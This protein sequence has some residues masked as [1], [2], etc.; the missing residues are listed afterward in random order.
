MK[1][2]ILVPTYKI[3]FLRECIDSI[4]AQTY[5]DFE[6][7]IVNDASPYDIDSIVN[8]YHDNRIRYYK[9]EINYGAVNVVDNWNKCLSYAKGDYVI[10]MGDDDKLLPC[11]LEEYN[12]LIIQYPHLDIYHGWTEIIN[13][14]SEVTTL[15]E[16]RPIWESVYSMMW[17]RWKYRIQFIG[18]FLFKTSKLKEVG[19]FY[20]LPLAW[21]SDDVTSYIL[22]EENGIANTQVTV[23]QYRRFSNTISRSSRAKDKIDALEKENIWY[24]YFLMKKPQNYLD[25]I[26]WDN[27]NKM[28]PGRLPLR[29]KLAIFEELNKG[30]FS[31]WSLFFKNRKEYQIKTR[32]LVKYLIKKI[33]G[34]Y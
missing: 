13:E 21:G 10:C 30:N 26:F 34:K 24:Q 5:I 33:I 6:L 29:R 31:Q 17:N 14:N 23:F 32:T 12:K 4:L 2:S 28:F 11:C 18:D 8:S 25:I 27:L 19:G 7:I 3:Q 22:A 9:N 1:Y 16:P 15:Q 20:K